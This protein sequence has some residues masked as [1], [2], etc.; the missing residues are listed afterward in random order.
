MA[1]AARSAK[2]AHS[3]RRADVKDNAI[4]DKEVNTA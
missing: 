4:I 2:P 3:I 1:S